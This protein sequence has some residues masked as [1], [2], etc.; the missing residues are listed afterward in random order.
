MLHGQILR[1]KAKI[2]FAEI[3]Y[4][5]ELKTTERIESLKAIRLKIAILKRQLFQ[6]DSTYTYSRFTVH[7]ALFIPLSQ[8]IYSYLICYGCHKSYFK[9]ISDKKLNADQ[10]ASQFYRFS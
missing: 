4:D 3:V 2:Q 8:L 9:A 7:F 1:L 6:I 5:R 10:L